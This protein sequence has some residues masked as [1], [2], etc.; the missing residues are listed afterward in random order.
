[1]W[2]KAIHDFA[3]DLCHAIEVAEGYR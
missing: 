2:I 1:M 3:G